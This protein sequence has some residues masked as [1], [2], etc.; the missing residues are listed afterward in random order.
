[1]AEIRRQDGISGEFYVGANGE[2]IPVGVSMEEF[3]NKCNSSADGR[4]CEGSDGPGR[5]ADPGTEDLGKKGYVSRGGVTP[6]KAQQKELDKKIKEETGK[7]VWEY[8]RKK[9]AFP[10][11]AIKVSSLNDEYDKRVRAGAKSAFVAKC[12]KEEQDDM[13]RYLDSIGSGKGAPARNMTDY[14]SKTCDS[15]FEISQAGESRRAIDDF[16]KTKEY[17]EIEEERKKA[18]EAHTPEKIKSDSAERDKLEAEM[19][20]KVKE[21]ENRIYDEW[22]AANAPKPKPK[23]EEKPSSG[24]SGSKKKKPWWKFWSLEEIVA[25]SAEERALAFGVVEPVLGFG[26]LEPLAEGS[27]AREIAAALGVDGDEEFARA[28]GGPGNPEALISYWRDGEGA[29]RI[30]WGTEG[31]F[32]RCM[33]LVGKYLPDDAGGFCQNRHI[34]IYG[35]AN[36]TRDAKAKARGELSEE[37]VI[38]EAEIEEFCKVDGCSKETHSSGKCITHYQ[39]MRRERKGTTAANAKGKYKN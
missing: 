12:V 9:D 11:S 5:A 16:K 20:A 19:K 32:T 23:K 35:E 10:S 26:G 29:D 18:L 13:N 33:R 17:A 2:L 37:N 28:R 39:Q 3:Y 30:G 25:M 22:A 4:F 24:S 6:T 34:E 21:A 27:M 15:A 36:A 38:L 31:D 7:I 1:M 8:E 14:Y